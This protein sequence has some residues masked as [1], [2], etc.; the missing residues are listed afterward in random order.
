MTK[1]IR[2]MAGKPNSRID[3]VESWT[4]TALDA[5]RFSHHTAECN[6][7]TTNTL[8]I[9]FPELARK[10]QYALSRVRRLN[11]RKTILATTMK[12]ERVELDYEG[13]RCMFDELCARIDVRKER[14]RLITLE[15]V[16][17]KT[18]LEM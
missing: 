1:L 15:N 5:N 3:V 17:V 8:C 7:L 18:R 16:E 2:T 11:Q 13:D 14:E 6:M 4:D 12:L 10:R 9:P